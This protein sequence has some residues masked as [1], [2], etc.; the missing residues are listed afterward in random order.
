MIELIR[1]L[2][3]KSTKIKKKNYKKV[4]I[5]FFKKEY[6]YLFIRFNHFTLNVTFVHQLLK[7]TLNL[8]SLHVNIQFKSDVCGD[9]GTCVASRMKSWMTSCSSLD[10]QSL[11]VLMRVTV[12]ATQFMGSSLLGQYTNSSSVYKKKRRAYHIISYHILIY[13]NTNIFN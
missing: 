9:W 10:K 3:N 7:S 1:K 4:N 2:R 13:S 11:S 12:K 8:N 6:N 5:S